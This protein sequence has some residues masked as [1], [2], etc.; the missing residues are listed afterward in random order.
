L[1]REI[2]ITSTRRG[3]FKESVNERDLGGVCGRGEKEKLE[4]KTSF[5]KKSDL[6]RLGSIEVV[7]GSK[8]KPRRLERQLVVERST[9]ERGSTRNSQALIC[10]RGRARWP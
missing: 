4:E 7:V 10:F 5:F 3:K 2:I 1:Q 8:K 6:R 9:T